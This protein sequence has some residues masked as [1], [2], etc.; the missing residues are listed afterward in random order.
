MWRH[1]AIWGNSLVVTGLTLAA[2]V[3]KHSLDFIQ[4]GDKIS[5]TIH[6]VFAPKTKVVIGGMGELCRQIESGGEIIF[7]LKCNPNAQNYLTVKLWGSDAQPCLVFLAD[8]SGKRYGSYLS[9]MPEIAYN[10]GEPEFLNRFI[11]VTIPIPKELTKGKRYVRLKLVAVG[12]VAPYAPPSQ[13]ERSLK[14]LSRGI[15]RV[16]T[17][18]D[19]FFTPEPDEK[20]GKPPLFKGRPCR[21]L[22]ELIILNRKQIDEAIERLLQSQIYGPKWKERIKNGEIP[23]IAYGATTRATPPTS[24]KGQAFLDWLVQRTTAGNCADFGIVG[25]FARA[26][27]W[28]GSKFHRAYELLERIVCALD[29]F[30]RAQGVNGGFTAQK[31]IGV[32]ERA[33]GW[34]CIEGYG[35]R[36]LGRAF[37]EVADHIKSWGLLDEKIDDDYDPKTPMI[38]RREVY[39][40]MFALHRDY[41]VR[42]ARGHATNQDLFQVQ[43]MWLCN[44]AL[45]HL[46]PELVWPREEALKFV[47]SAIGLA[48]DIYGGYWFSPKG[49]PLEP[50]GTL[51]GGYCGNYGRECAHLVCEMAE[52]TGDEKVALQALKTVE[53]MSYFFY[54]DITADGYRC[55][56]REEV[57]S[58][59]NNFSPGR[60]DYPFNL[61]AAAVL[62][63]PV[64]L[65]AFQIWLND[66]N[67]PLPFD[68]HNAHFVTMV[69]GRLYS[70]RYF[71][72]LLTQRVLKSNLNYR[73][74]MEPGQP[75]K[76]WVDEWGHV[77]VVRHEDGSRLYISL[78]W[79]RG[80][81]PGGRGPDFVRTN[82]LA[83]IHFTTPVIDRVATI[84][85]EAPYGFGR[86][87]ICRY[88]PYFIAM[89][90]CKSETF[91]VN[92]PPAK[93]VVDLV[94]GRR[95][96]SRKPL[97]LSPQTSVVLYYKS[98]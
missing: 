41:L 1:I 69:L 50:W 44:E 32:P 57:I 6:T 81:K 28:E 67:E 15:Y 10:R 75:D 34:S 89:N 49:L 22:D 51:G 33:R 68:W 26:Y 30:A 88:G 3:V 65:R 74:F 80:F 25:I 97:R 83:R 45:R 8:E 37:L 20:L 27:S 76:A 78:Q 14:N 13:K 66:G 40:R 60:I 39:A 23:A 63:S 9:E 77:V 38:P 72:Q 86:L 5:E 4:F 73:L 7:T 95:L 31:W 35:T 53:A 82:N 2:D 59:R 94:S 56:R 62:K 71:E 19:P 24:L 58:T 17:H 11:Y 18:T 61:Y 46:K 36:W 54:P 52:I 48:P 64:A 70:A 47:Y 43:S 96:D 42:E 92:A 98:P 90:L 84:R 21:P 85:M 29:Y 16:Y 87:Y 79:R 12:S 91:T 93:S 55:W